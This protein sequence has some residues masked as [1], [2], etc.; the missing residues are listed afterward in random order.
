MKQALHP[1]TRFLLNEP[2]IFNEKLECELTILIFGLATSLER[3]EKMCKM[4]HVC[5]V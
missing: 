4:V 3:D 5:A 2:R 1:T